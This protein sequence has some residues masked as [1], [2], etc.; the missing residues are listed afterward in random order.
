MMDEST[1]S[2]SLASTALW[3]AAVRAKE[4]TREDALFHDPWA[5]LLAGKAGQEWMDQR[6]E[7]GVVPIVLRTRFFDDFLQNIVREEHIDQV[8]LLAAGLDTRAFRLDW[9]AGTRF[10]E[11]DQPAV[12]NHAEQV[13][14]SAGALP[15][16]SLQL[17]RVDLARSWTGEL[18]EAG[19]D[20]G[21]PSV[22][23]LE[24]F[25]FYLPSEQIIR[26][27]EQVS[28]LA[29]ESS[30]M[31]FDIVNGLTLTSRYT[32][33]WIEMQAR[34][35]APWIGYLDDPVG[36]LAGLGWKA[37]LAQA[38]QPGLNFGR[39]RLPVLPITMPNMPHHWLVTA[40]RE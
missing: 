37:E 8:V 28:T 31:G 27:L 12:L 25:L 14:R 39:W 19:F 15:A 5:A 21:R 2:Q 30:W 3:T 33:E 17:V 13:M 34:A 20:S 16:C 1:S 7:D 26:L 9:P 24:G 18:I 32:K 35:G 23:L 29:A 38:G 4:S 36:F 11:L 40:R 10:Y 6:S 22:W